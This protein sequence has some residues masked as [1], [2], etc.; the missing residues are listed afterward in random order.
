M[1]KQSQE[2]IVSY[3]CQLIDLPPSAS[4]QQL[5]AA[6]SKR[7]DFYW[8]GQGIVTYKIVNTSDAQLDS[9]DSDHY[10]VVLLDTN[11]GR[12]IVLL[13]P[14]TGMSGEWLGWYH[15]TTDTKPS[16]QP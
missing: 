6:L 16:A 7:D 9:R 5:V 11:V 4:P 10:T 12:R 3:M 1:L 8:S 15:R 2:A 14:S 13:K